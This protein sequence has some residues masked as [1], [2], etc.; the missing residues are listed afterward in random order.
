MHRR[1]KQQE[2][3]AAEAIARAAEAERR[4]LEE[5]RRAADIEAQRIEDDNLTPEERR[6]RDEKRAILQLIDEKPAE[7]AMLVKTW[8]QEDD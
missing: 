7:V 2:R 8:L 4:R 3:E 5:E 1:K 6:Q